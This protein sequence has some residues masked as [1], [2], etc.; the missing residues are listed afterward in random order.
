MMEK[1]EDN[2]I[3]LKISK[4]E[5]LTH[6]TFL[7]RL[8]FP[9][10]EWV[11]G[12][13]VSGHFVFHADIDGKHY[14]RKYTPVSPV[15]QK[16]SADFIIKVYRNQSEMYPTGGI[17]SRHLDKNMN[18][19][20]TIKVEGPVGLTKYLGN[21]KFQIKQE[22]LEHRKKTLILC[23]GGTG[24]TP[25]LSIAQAAI[26]SKDDMKIS[27]IF[28]NKTKDDILC[29]SA[30]KDLEKRSSGNFKVYY[31]LTRHDPAKHGKWDGL[32][33]RVSVDML[34]QCGLP[35]PQD[36]LFIGTCGPPGFHISIAEPL[37]ALGYKPN[38]HFQEK[39][40]N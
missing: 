21:G 5:I 22:V 2:Q 35:D 7:I 16:G 10:P 29:D 18:K 38:V 28:C 25:M 40:K 32:Q 3:S 31:T 20:D 9:N 23:A 15:S 8:E 4:K 6:D 14:S 34:K 24:V 11:S 1:D 36:D 27:F 33:G 37:K 13:F 17:F 39:T 26:L 19:G 12:L 30:I